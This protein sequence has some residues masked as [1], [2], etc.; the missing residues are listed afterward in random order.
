MT[1]R[2]RPAEQ[3]ATYDP[4]A[5]EPVSRE[6]TLRELRRVLARRWPSVAAVT[7][8][9]VAAALA[10]YVLIPVTYTATTTV[11]VTSPASSIRETSAGTL[12]AETATDLALLNSADGAKL[13]PAAGSSQEVDEA[14]ANG[15]EAGNPEGTALIELS[16]TADSAALA[17]DAANA[18]AERYL[19]LRTERANEARKAYLAALEDAGKQAPADINERRL[20]ATVYGSDVGKIVQPAEAPAQASSVGLPA[21]LVAGL[22]AGLLLGAFVAL[23]RERRDPRVRTVERL[24][25]ALG[26]PAL[27]ADDLRS[28]AV[29]RSV[30]AL[31][32]QASGGMPAR[33][34]V[35]VPGGS[36][37]VATLRLSDGLHAAG[38]AAPK[39]PGEGPRVELVPLPDPAAA[40]DLGGSWW[41]VEAVVVVC[42]KSVQVAHV[43]RCVQAAASTR[44]PM[45]GVLNDNRAEVRPVEAEAR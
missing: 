41:S 43:T 27:A 3:S 29:G 2:T 42:L 28:A 20:D 15:L 39:V 35:V 24:A 45:L 38:I 19:M 14:I 16:V 23:V 10:V 31:A 26:A 4:A 18:A 37:G 33:V 13:L 30:G 25:D 8:L 32:L 22:L 34:G 21:Y 7:A 11:Q 1:T 17:A 44:A 36:A 6:L 12:A 5:P 40:V 9:C